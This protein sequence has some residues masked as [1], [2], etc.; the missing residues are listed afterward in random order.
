MTSDSDDSLSDENESIISLYELNNSSSEDDD[1]LAEEFD[2]NSINEWKWETDN[3]DFS[4]SFNYF[5]GY[6]L[7]N[8]KTIT[9]INSFQKFISED[10]FKLITDQTN[11]YE[12]QH[13]VQ[14]GNSF[15]QWKEVGEDE[16]LAFIEILFIMGFHKLP[17]IRD[18]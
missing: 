7:G 14:S 18:Y 6:A 11:I 5:D 3:S 2:E 9:P 10:V 15:T 4:T 8:S 13:R 12:K 1:S 17:R 16:I